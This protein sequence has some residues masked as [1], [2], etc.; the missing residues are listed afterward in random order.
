[1]E[2]ALLY[3]LREKHLSFKVREKLTA[4]TTDLKFRGELNTTT[5]D[6]RHDMTGLFAIL[7]TNG[8]RAF[9]SNRRSADSTIA[10]FGI[11]ARTTFDTRSK[12]GCVTVG[13]WGRGK[14]ILDTS[15]DCWARVDVETMYNL[16][17]GRIENGIHAR[18]HKIYQSLTAKQDLKCTIGWEGFGVNSYRQIQG[19]S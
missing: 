8:F 10:A 12:S 9:K 4:E 2:T 5:G 19:V 11:G 17:R 3:R 7:P 6:W 1:M 14:S 16:D 13:F 15:G 18:I